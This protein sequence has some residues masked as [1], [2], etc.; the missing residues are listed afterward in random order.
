MD[1]DIILCWAHLER[2]IK[3]AVVLLLSHKY[4][5]E[6]TWIAP[7]SLACTGVYRQVHD[8]RDNFT[9][10]KNWFS[11]FMGSFSYAIAVSLFHRQEHFYKEMPHWF[12]FLYEREFSQIWLSGIRSSIVATFNSSV[13]RVGVLVQLCQCHQDQISVD[14]LCSFGIPVHSRSSRVSD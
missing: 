1:A 11:L 2:N 6:I 8:L 12:S 9:H 4:A 14:W 5:P 3:D 7:T 13:D 10:S